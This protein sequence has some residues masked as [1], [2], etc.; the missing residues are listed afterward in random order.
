MIRSCRASSYS[1]LSALIRFSAQYSASAAVR[2]SRSSASSIALKGV[3]ISLQAVSVDAL[4]DFLACGSAGFSGH[5]AHA[6][7]SVPSWNAQRQSPVA[8]ASP[9]TNPS[10]GLGPRQLWQRIKVGRF[11]RR[12][13]VSWRSVKREL[14]GRL[15]ARI[16]SRVREGSPKW[17]GTMSAPLAFSAHANRIALEIL[18]VA[19]CRQRP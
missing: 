7:I 16:N 2:M 13:C 5:F 8:L 3:A 12:R 19:S 6:N 17:D 1:S 9:R 15:L 11:G 4:V 18:P 14:A 10:N